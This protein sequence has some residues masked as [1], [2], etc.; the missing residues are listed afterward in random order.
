VIGLARLFE[1]TQK[2][3]YSTAANFFWKTVTTKYTYV[4]GGN[5][6][7]EYFQSPNSISKYITDQTCESCNTY[8]MLKLTRHLYSWNTSAAVSSITTS[9][10]ISTT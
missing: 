6:D 7:R 3:E 9:G 5:S 8:N 1:I 10:R 2:P 4:I